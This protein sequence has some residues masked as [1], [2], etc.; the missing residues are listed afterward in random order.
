MPWHPRRARGH[1]NVRINGG[2]SFAF[3]MPSSSR[4]ASERKCV[5]EQQCIRLQ[6]REQILLLQ[7]PDGAG[8]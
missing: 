5:A 7:L 3:D 4:A 6:V 1:K 2:S 8:R